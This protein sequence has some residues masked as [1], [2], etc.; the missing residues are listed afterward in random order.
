MTDSTLRP[1]ERTEDVNDT[2]RRILS[3]GGTPFQL[4]QRLTLYVREALRASEIPSETKTESAPSVCDPSGSAPETSGDDASPPEGKYATRKAHWTKR[5]FAPLSALAGDQR[6]AETWQPIATAPK[7]GTKILLWESEVSNGYT[8]GRWRS[9]HW[10][11]DGLYKAG[12]CW[13]DGVYAV[14]AERWMP[15]PSPPQTGS[16]Q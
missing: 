3:E 10:K 9:G 12:G 14:I 1:S 11:A 2:I 6:Q 15:W 4:E 5:D 13:W 8:D 7:D 16:P